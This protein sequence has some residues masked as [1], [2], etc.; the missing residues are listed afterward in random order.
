MANLRDRAQDMRVIPQP[1]I[2]EAL[3]GASLEITVGKAKP[4]RVDEG[5]W[6]QVLRQVTVAAEDF[7]LIHMLRTD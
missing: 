4:M 6:M 2:T 1:V 7:V 5:D 3:F